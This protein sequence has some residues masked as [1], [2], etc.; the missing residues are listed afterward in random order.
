MFFP[1]CS[2]NHVSFPLTSRGKDDIVAHP[3]LQ[4]NE[5]HDI[6]DLV[7]IGYAVRGYT[8]GFTVLYY[9]YL[10]FLKSQIYSLLFLGCPY[11]AAWDMYERA[12]IVFCPYSYIVDQLIRQEKLEDKL[13]GAIIIF[14]EA[15]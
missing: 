10:L 14:D 12:Q 7:K 11:F 3:S 13:N 1:L 5:V 15:Q 4:Q 9:Y 8:F 6:E 2:S